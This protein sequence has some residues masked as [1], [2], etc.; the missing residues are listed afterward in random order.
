MTLS[1]HGRA[2]PGPLH[3]LP[4][5]E[6]GLT[7]A[8]GHALDASPRLLTAFWSE[9][10]LPG[11]PPKNGIRVALQEPAEE[12]LTDCQ[13]RSSMRRQGTMGL[14][15]RIHLKEERIDGK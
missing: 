15:P 10:G 7:F 6:N 8:L 1:L 3:L 4:R 2:A 5:H 14:R 11:R 13:P 12:C 9:L